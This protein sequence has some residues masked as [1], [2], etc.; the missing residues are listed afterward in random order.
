MRGKGV[1][2]YPFH[3]QKVQVARQSLA[4]AC[5][6]TGRCEIN[7]AGMGSDPAGGSYLWLL[8]GDWHYSFPDGPVA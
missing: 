6:L 5:P 3:L 1:F 4:I 8:V 2:P 7:M